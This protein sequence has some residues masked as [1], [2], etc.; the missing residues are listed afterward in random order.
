MDE[1]VPLSCLQRLLASVDLVGGVLAVEEAVGVLAL[2][3]D[4]AHEL[5]VLLQ[6]VVPEE[7]RQRLLLLQG[8]PLP[9]HRRELLEREVERDQIP[10]EDGWVRHVLL[11]LLVEVG[12][13]LLGSCFLDDDR[14]P[15]LELVHD[16]GR[17]H[18]SLLYSNKGRKG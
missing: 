8:Q 11:L 14:D 9:D 7:D 15:L 12:E 17:L 13:L 3:E 1:P 6:P 4:L 18:H 10:I 2:V 16:L 5:L